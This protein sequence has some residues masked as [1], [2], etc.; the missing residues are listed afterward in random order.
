MKTHKDLDVWKKSIA[1]VT[2]LY[3]LT[4][5]FPKD[6]IYGLIQQLRRSAVF[7]PSNI[8]EGHGRFHFQENIQFCRQD[9]GSLCELQDYNTTYNDLNFINNHFLQELDSKMN[10]AI[11]ILDG[12]IRFLTEQKDDNN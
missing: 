12:Y 6:E 5:S 4:K 7:I 11:K 1:L 9:R 3:Q 2:A 8:A 10:K